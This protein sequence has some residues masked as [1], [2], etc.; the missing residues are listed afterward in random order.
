MDHGSEHGTGSYAEI[1]QFWK[2][3]SSAIPNI[4]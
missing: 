4:P 1:W 2:G 3:E